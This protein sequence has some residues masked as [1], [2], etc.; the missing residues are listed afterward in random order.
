[1]STLKTVLRI[2]G[3]VLLLLGWMCVPRPTS[4]FTDSVFKAWSDVGAFVRFGVGLMLAGV[5][6]FG[7]SFLVRGEL[8]D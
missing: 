4:M 6:T 7:A 8:I 3:I 5:A 2:G 1:M